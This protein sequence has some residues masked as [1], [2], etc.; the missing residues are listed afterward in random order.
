[1]PVTNE[2]S[3]VAWLP[4]ILSRSRVLLP[5]LVWLCAV[6]PS[7]A[8][9][10]E[11]A[12]TPI[13]ATV[14]GATVRGYYKVVVEAMNGI[15]RA[16]H[17]GSAITFRPSSP[18]GGLMALA[19]EKADFAVAGGGPEIRNAWLGEAPYKR[20][21]ADRFQHVLHVHSE[22]VVY[23][24]MTE[25]WAER[26]GVRSLSD[27][28]RKKPAMRLALNDRANL[29]STLGGSEALF[30][31][32]G[33]SSREV[34][35]WG[36][37]LIR[38]NSAIGLAALQDGKADVFVNARFLPDAKVRDIA[39]H[40]A[41]RWVEAERE[42]ILEAGAAWGYAAQSVGP[43]HFEFLDRETWALLQ[44]ST[45]NAGAHVPEDVVYRFVRALDEGAPQLR[46][47]HPSLAGF[48]G[49]EMAKNPADIPVHPG[50]LRYYREQ[51]Y[52]P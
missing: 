2:R 48:G 26:E 29:Q 51:G 11:A 3:P 45:M 9:D 14:T 40:R 44:W 1:M 19:R 42:R 34:E 38:G 12:A 41:L 6:G 47:L 16:A 37:K 36:G 21:L 28:A 18:A 43:E 33:F 32:H 10:S 46:E 35:A 25:A 8:A 27:I 15:V 31:A 52:L 5:C 24:L 7:Q 22:Q 13:R 23:V 4:A 30:G 50:A 49:R 39:R 20:A 17:P